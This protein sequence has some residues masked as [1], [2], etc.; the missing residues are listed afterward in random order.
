MRD[1]LF[2]IMCCPC[3]GLWLGAPKYRSRVGP[4]QLSSAPHDS[5]LKGLLEKP[6]PTEPLCPV[7]TENLNPD[8]VVT[9]SIKDRVRPIGSGAVNG[10]R[11]RRIFI[12]RSM[13]SDVVARLRRELP[14]RPNFSHQFSPNSDDCWRPAVADCDEAASS[15]PREHRSEARPR[16]P[17]SSLRSY[18]ISDRDRPSD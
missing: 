16:R 12:Q 9:K 15:H 13:R 6:V 18:L 7:C 2:A 3:T 4:N 11:D 5:N 10:V 17:A 8:V 14:S 1:D